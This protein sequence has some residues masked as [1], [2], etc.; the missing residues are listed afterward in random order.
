MLRSNLFEPYRTIG[1]VTDGIPM[2]F[3]KLGSESFITVA[4][5]RAWQVFSC[6]KLRLALVAPQ[7]ELPIIAI[8]TFNDITF[9]SIGQQIIV[10]R[11]IQEVTR[12]DILTGRATKL[13][14][15]GTVLLAVSDAGEMYV[16]DLTDLKHDMTRSEDDHART[17]SNLSTAPFVPS[18]DTTLT[19]ISIPN[20]KPKKKS[21]QKIKSISVKSDGKIHPITRI[22]F[23]RPIDDPDAYVTC[24]AHPP[25]Y[26]NKVLVC[27]STGMMELYNFNTGKRVHRYKNLRALCEGGSMTEQSSHASQKQS[28]FEVLGR[29]ETANKS[30]QRRLG[31]SSP[32]TITSIAASSP[33]VDVIAVG[34]S[35]GEI[36][37]FNTKL[38]APIHVFKQDGPVTALAFREDGLPFLCSASSVSPTATLSTSGGSNEGANSGGGSNLAVWDL[39]NK[40]IHHVVYHAHDRSTSALHFIPGEPILISNGADNA[41]RTWLFTNN[42]AKSNSYHLANNNHLS[43]L[44]GTEV[45]KLRER[46]GHAQSPTHVA[47][48]G[49]DALITCGADRTVRYFHV[50]RDQQACQLSQGNLEKKEKKMINNTNN[51]YNAYDNEGSLRIGRVTQ[52]AVNPAKSTEWPTILTTHE[53]DGAGIRWNAETK[54]INHNK[55]MN[56]NAPAVASATTCSISSCG[57]Y[58]FLGFGDGRV[59]RYNMQSGLYRGRYGKGSNSSAST[60]AGLTLKDQTALAKKEAKE[61]AR[62]A[63]KGIEPKGNVSE[64]HTLAVT[65]MIDCTHR[66]SQLYPIS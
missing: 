42:N 31:L 22:V 65:G 12:L 53:N 32:C 10:W 59:E 8:A 58:G 64:E 56:T 40:R 20:T 21:L 27:W 5:G 26:I 48:Y 63:K 49:N 44:S 9:T 6:E 45:I 46:S 33:V 50:V 60:N 24:I 29:G 51:N 55:L 62:L 11:G 15:V 4:I 13:L 7:R 14:T 47:Y 23:E 36:I 35:G 34:T 38:D 54:S 1:I 66:I 28:I 25:T 61:A 37:L 3:K 41:I 17:L 30:R 52:L 43:N 39:Q 57:N 18:D 2:A 16:W 19:T